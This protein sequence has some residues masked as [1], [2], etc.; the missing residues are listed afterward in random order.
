MALTN[1]PN[2]ISSFGVPVLPVSADPKSYATHYFVDGDNG[3]DAFDGASPDRPYATMAKAFSV[4]ASGDTIHVRGNIREELTTPAQ[5]FD[6]TIIGAS[7]RPRHADTTPAGGESGA[8]W[9]PPASPTA[10]TPLLIIQQQGWTIQN[11]LFDAPVDA[12]AIRL[13][14]NGA[15]GN[16]ERDASHA[17]IIGCRFDSGLIGIENNGGAAFVL[18]QGCR[19]YRLTGSGAAGIKCTSTAIAV[20]LNWQIIA[21]HFAGN[22][23][24]L[25][26]S[27]SGSEIR[28]NTFGN[29]T[30]TLSVDVQSNSGQGA[31]NVLTQ[32]YLS[33]TYSATAY[34][35]GTDNEWA[36]NYNS[37]TGGVTAA[38]PA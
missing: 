32:N 23:S 36:G 8:T 20:P 16:A 18:V 7:N 11:I 5:V 9:R 35:P 6:V 10:A 24:H 21:S 15:A 12:A 25:L 28:W 4:I 37:L 26:S 13:L 31:N 33:G 17:S 27:L 30:A 1:F 2:G 29:F 38:D 14:R 22:A 19:F 34:P 3:N